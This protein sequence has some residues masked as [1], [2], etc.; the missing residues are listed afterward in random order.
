MGSCVGIDL[1][2][3]YSKIAYV[4]QFGCVKAIDNAEG[5]YMT[6]SVVYFEDSSQIIVG[7]LA[8]ENAM[9]D[10]ENTILM[11]KRMI[12]KTNFAIS[13]N[14]REISPEEVLSY[15]LL[16]IVTDAATLL[17][18]EIDG[19]VITVPAYFCANECSVVRRAAE[20][21]GINLISILTETTASVISYNLCQ[22]N[23]ESTVLIYDLGGASL[24]ISVAKI[25]EGKVNVI[26]L[27]G[28]SD[29][30]G[31][32]WDN[33]LFNYF[34]DEVF[35]QTGI[36]DLDEYTLQDFRIKAEKVKMKLSV[37]NSVPVV[38]RANNENVNL[39]ITREIFEKITMSLL[40]ETIDRT[41]EVLYEAKKQGH[42]I[43]EII[44]V[45]GGS[46]MPQVRQILF[47]KY[48]LNPK[49]FEPD[50]AIAK[51]A[52]IYAMENKAIDVRPI[53]SKSYGIKVLQE[54]KELCHHS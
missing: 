18:D 21:A 26:C 46:K 32:E 42:E 36:E 31:I 5:T 2:A 43:N 53:C 35:S 30:G 13:H 50:L 33:A 47:D 27:G 54:D 24:D 41:E 44:L 20:L 8:K 3:T 23:E 9:I 14:E 17:E 40:K 51:G 38:L 15:I 22:K 34:K 29:L 7:D 48:G 45:G 52:A 39:E 19:A 49:L 12:G 25:K 28:D 10:P 4:D 11:A 6:P 37:R 16:K 1:G